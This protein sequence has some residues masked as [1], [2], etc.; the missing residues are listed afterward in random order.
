MQ[1]PQENIEDFGNK[2]NSLRSTMAKKD[3]E[4]KNKQEQLEKTK[5]AEEKARWTLLG[6]TV[7]VDVDGIV[8]HIFTVDG[9]LL[10]FLFLPG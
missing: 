9:M 1:P 8:L 10:I 5:V 7:D 3:E 6:R 2:M 4:L